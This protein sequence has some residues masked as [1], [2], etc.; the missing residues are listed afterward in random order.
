MQKEASAGE[1]KKF[2]RHGRE[3]DWGQS[4]VE[5]D[6]VSPQHSLNPLVGS[7]NSHQYTRTPIVE[8]TI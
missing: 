4:V 8:L 1:E 3:K 5:L 6:Y 7:I 2:Q